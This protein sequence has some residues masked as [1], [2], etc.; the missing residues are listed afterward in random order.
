MIKFAWVM[1][2]TKYVWKLF[3]HTAQ[4]NFYCGK[5]YIMQ[6]LLPLPFWCV[7]FSSVKYIHTI[8]KQV[9]NILFYLQNET[10]FFFPPL[11]LDLRNHYST[12]SFCDLFSY[13]I[14]MQ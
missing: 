5:N 1:I 14:G 11:H 6:N 8:L 13:F 10:A 3:S 12:F 2:H 9:S 4:Q 7:L